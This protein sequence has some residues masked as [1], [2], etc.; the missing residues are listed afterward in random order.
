ML[1]EI[2]FDIL[3]DTGEN[4]S[5]KALSKNEFE[6]RKNFSFLRNIISEG[7]KIVWGGSRHLL[8]EQKGGLMRGDKTCGENQCICKKIR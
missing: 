8:R 6:R 4:V 3:L 2:A 5:V 1:I 7:I